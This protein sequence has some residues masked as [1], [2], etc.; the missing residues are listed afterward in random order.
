MDFVVQL[1][2][3]HIQSLL[4]AFTAPRFCLS[5]LAVREAIASRRMFNLLDTQLGDKADFWLLTD[6]PFDQSRFGRRVQ[7]DLLGVR[8]Q[9]STPEDTILQKLFWAKEAGGS[10]K[11]FIDAL[12][13]YEVQGETLDQSYLDCWAD[14]LQVV[15][16]LEQLRQQ[17]N[18]PGP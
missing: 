17:A 3:A 14:H 2:T 12:R 16:S 11:Q 10:Q 1:S 13:V 8:C 7:D 4:A 5:E 18:P 9:V 6:S 15:D